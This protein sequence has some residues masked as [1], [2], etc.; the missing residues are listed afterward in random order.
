MLLQNQD[1]GSGQGTDPMD[2]AG[3]PR[4]L[5]GTQSSS[6]ERR[7]QAPSMPFDQLPPAKRHAAAY[8]SQFA[9]P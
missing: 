8:S 2:L 7:R 1:V 5:T 4:G 6:G 9:L 3:L